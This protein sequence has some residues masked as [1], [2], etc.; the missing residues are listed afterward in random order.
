MCGWRKSLGLPR[1][2]IADWRKRDGIGC[3]HAVEYLT[4]CEIH[5]DAIDP[6]VSLFWHIMYDVPIGVIVIVAMI[7]I[8]IILAI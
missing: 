1:G 2:Q 7:I 8:A 6:E 5:R 4:H 3:L